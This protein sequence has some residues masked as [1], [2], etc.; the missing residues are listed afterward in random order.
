M[1]G[2]AAHPATDGPGY[3]AAVLRV[4][5]IRDCAPH[6]AS[7]AHWHTGSIPEKGYAGSTSDTVASQGQQL[8]KGMR[9]QESRGEGT[10]HDPSV[11]AGRS[12]SNVAQRF[13]SCTGVKS[14]YSGCPS[15]SDSIRPSRS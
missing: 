9:Q 10:H 7:T 13:D 3:T 6:P 5:L 2:A 8:L 15:M 1:P 14:T 12:L 4:T 11:Y